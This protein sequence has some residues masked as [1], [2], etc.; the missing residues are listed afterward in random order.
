MHGDIR[1]RLAA[2]AVDAGLTA[3]A[4]HAG[5]TVAGDLVHGRAEVLLTEGELSGDAG[6]FHRVLTWDSADAVDAGE[7]TLAVVGAAVWTVV[8]AAAAV[9]AVAAFA[10]LG[11]DGAAVIANG[12]DADAVQPTLS[13]ACALSGDRWRGHAEVVVAAHLTRHGADFVVARRDAGA[14]DAGLARGAFVVELTG[15][16]HVA[17]LT[18]DAE[19]TRRTDA[20]HV[21]SGWKPR[22]A[23][24]VLADEPFVTLRVVLAGVGVGAGAVDAAESLVATR[25]AFAEATF[26]AAELAVAIKADEALIA[27]RVGGAVAGVRDGWRLGGLNAEAALAAVAFSAITVDAAL[28]N[29]A[30]V[31]ADFT[32]GALV[33]TTARGPWWRFNGTAAESIAVVATSVVAV[34]AFA[35]T[36][37]ERGKGSNK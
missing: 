1:L 20:R 22:S 6:A 23:A 17:A 4:V 34:V 10:T 13:V 14:V 27:L 7:A 24:P 37:S 15:V 8:G 33:V 29:A 36:A 3:A 16:F 30:Y 2:D 26:D 28:G 31:C 25:V 35:L 21:A 12:V 9:V 18:R 32:L 5:L 19:E 11:V